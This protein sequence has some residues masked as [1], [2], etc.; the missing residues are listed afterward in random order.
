MQEPT[1]D[2]TL[3]A[4]VEPHIFLC[5]GLHP[6]TWGSGRLLQLQPV[7]KR[8]L[9]QGVVAVKTEFLADVGPVVFNRAVMDE[10]FVR[11]RLAR[12]AVSHQAQDLP[13]GWCEIL[14]PWLALRER[15]SAAAALEKMDSKRGRY[16]VLAVCNSPKRFDD[17]G[18]RAVFEEVA[19]G[20][21]VHSGVEEI[22]F[23]V[24]G[25]KDDLNRRGNREAKVV[26][27]RLGSLY[28]HTTRLLHD[29][30]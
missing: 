20:S 24:N 29:L 16:V 23:V 18:Q 10:Q 6:Q 3:S 11:D 27:S 21:Q 1:E 19:L 22:F 15:L 13:L 8:E 14:Q 12:F 17:F 30:P 7:L 28:N 26:Y 5:G 4:C 9:E 25:E 2:T